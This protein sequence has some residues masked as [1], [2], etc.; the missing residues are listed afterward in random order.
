MSRIVREFGTQLLRT[1]IV[2]DDDG[3]LWWERTVGAACPDEFSSLR[4]RD[5]TADAPGMVKAEPAD[6][7]MRYRVDALW[8]VADCIAAGDTTPARVLGAFTTLGG[9]LAQLHGLPT[10]PPA[11]RAPR[12]NKR[13]RIFLTSRRET[14]WCAG[15]EALADRAHEIAHS[16]DCLQSGA[17]VRTVHGNATL[18]N[19]AAARDGS[20]ALMVGEDVASARPES[21]VGAP[22]GDLVEFAVAGRLRA[23]AVTESATALL[24]S[25]ALSIDTDL[26]R[27]ATAVRLLTH[28]SDYQRFAART[29]DRNYAAVMVGIALAVF[30]ADHLSAPDPAVAPV[31]GLLAALARPFAQ[32]ER[33]L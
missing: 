6:E 19:V 3:A 8:S 27:H 16:I 12:P 32:Q 1:R 24:S 22:L 30:D 10:H 33:N 25:Y 31:E 17:G 14:G 29:H 21:D 18:G 9:A 11:T 20:F 7:S 13:L 26:A 23:A 2:A 28:Y 5:F 15:E 4:V